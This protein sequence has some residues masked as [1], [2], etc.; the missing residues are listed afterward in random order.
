MKFQEKTSKTI[1]K[2]WPQD[3]EDASFIYRVLCLKE[4]IPLFPR[5]WKKNKKNYVNENN[6][7]IISYQSLLCDSNGTEDVT[8][9]TWAPV[10][11]MYTQQNTK[12]VEKENIQCFQI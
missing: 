2:R 3:S 6:I 10:G 5:I 8:I 11:A 7:Q 12:E 9:K 1:H 4:L